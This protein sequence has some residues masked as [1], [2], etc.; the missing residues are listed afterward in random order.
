MGQPPHFEWDEAKSRS[1]LAKHGVSFE[2]A[3]QIF[4]GPVLTFA[5]DRHDYGEWRE[6]AI[7]MADDLAIL[8]VV[9]VDRNGVIRII[10]AR[11][12]TR[13]ERG[14]YEEA[15]RKGTYG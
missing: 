11:P 10:S 6:I 2:R 12:A 1:N 8:T 3:R 13:S 4:N 7:G 5:D 15:I 14:R 9:H